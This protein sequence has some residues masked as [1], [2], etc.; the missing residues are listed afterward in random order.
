[1]ATVKGDVHDIGKNIV[2]VVLALQ[3][4]RGHRPGRDGPLREDPPQGA[5]STSVDMIGLSG[6][7]T[8][9]LDEMVHV[10]REM[11][12][13]GFDGAAADR[14]RDDERQAHRREDRP[15]LSRTGHPREG[16]LAERRRRR[17]AEPPRVARRARPRRTGPSRSRSATVVRRRAGSASSSPTPRR[18]GAASPSTGP[19]VAIAVP[20]VP[21]RPQSLADFPLAEIVPYIDW[22]PFFMTWELKGKYPAILDDPIVGAEARDLFDEGQGPARPDRRATSS[23]TAHGVYGFFPANSDGRRHRRLHRR[24]ADDRAVPVPLPPPAVGAPGA[25]RLPQPGRLRR[26]ARL[27]PGRLPRR[28]RRDRRASASRRWSTQFKARPRRLQRD[29]GQGPRRPAGRGLRRDAC[30]S[31]PARDWGYGRD[32]ATLD[33]RADRREVPRHPPG[34]R[35]SLLPRPHREG[36]ALAACSTPRRPPASG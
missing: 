34:R 29:H 10:A 22:S 28:L 36:D 35:L 8:P 9:S 14:R 18:C 15:A 3:R 33:R 6:L 11:E 4:L 20:G 1:M 16:R 7:I 13:E 32:E 5:A 30:T 24:V 19:P 12:R 31:R 17:S 23:L 2:G 27:G 21:R 26:P 25:D